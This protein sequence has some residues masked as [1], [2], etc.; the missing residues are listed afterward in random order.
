MVLNPSNKTH[1]DVPLPEVYKGPSRVIPP[2][3]RVLDPQG[4]LGQ[5][6]HDSSR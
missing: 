1:S 4:D 3:C 5:G 6:R 2:Q